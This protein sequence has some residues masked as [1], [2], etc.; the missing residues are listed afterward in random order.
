MLVACAPPAGDVLDAGG[1]TALFAEWLDD[2]SEPFAELRAALRQRRLVVLDAS[3][4]MLRF[5]RPRAPLCLAGDLTLPPFRERRFA[6]VLSF[7]SILGEPFPALR[8]LA[9][10]LAPGGTLL[11]TFLADDVAAAKAAFPAAALQPVTGGVEAG[12]DRAFL[13]R[14]R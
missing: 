14:R 3:V 12:Q 6:L 9:A 11:A 1:G 8:S 4:G 13:L 10:L 2:P 7:T 5:A